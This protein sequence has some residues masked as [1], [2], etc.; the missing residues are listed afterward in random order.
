MVFAAGAIKILIADDSGIW[1]EALRSFLQNQSEFEVIEE[2]TSI[3]EVLEGSET[4]KAD[5]VILEIALPSL[6]IIE[7]AD[8]LHEKNPDTRLLVL[9]SYDDD[10]HLKECLLA[11]VNA[12]I[13]KKSSLEDLRLGL[14]T[15][16]R[17]GIFI[18]AAIT[19]RLGS[20]LKRAEQPSAEDHGLS[21][22]E[23]QVLTLI[24]QGFTVKDVS[25][26]LKISL[27][28]VET[29]KLRSMK[30]LNLHSRAE[31]MIYALE[32]GWLMKKDET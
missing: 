17:G 29:H 26:H 24:A 14:L 6:N 18:D 28:T 20:I 5:I 22:R 11:G 1:R 12:Y 27:K 13:L 7:C 23:T 2:S 25:I 10:E 19:K 32:H 31:L 15:A 4:Q 9:T 21:E 8:F 16:F 3:S 30:K